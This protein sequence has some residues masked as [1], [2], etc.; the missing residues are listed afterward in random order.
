MLNDLPGD[1][2]LAN[3]RVYHW[4]LEILESLLIND[5]VRSYAVGC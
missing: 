1:L 4:L 2:Q 3:G 5:E